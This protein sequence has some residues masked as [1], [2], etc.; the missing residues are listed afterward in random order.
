MLHCL[1]PYTLKLY[2]KQMFTKYFKADNDGRGLQKL[3]CEEMTRRLWN[4]LLSITKFPVLVSHLT[5]A[6]AYC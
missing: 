6:K 3:S 2:A 4:K 1:G 5:E